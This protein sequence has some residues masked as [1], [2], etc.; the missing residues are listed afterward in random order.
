MKNELTSGF[1]NPPRIGIPG[2]MKLLVMVLFCLTLI[3]CGSEKDYHVAV[4]YYNGDKDTL[5]VHG[6]STGTIRLY[7]SG[8]LY[9]E[10]PDFGTPQ[11]IVCCNVRKFYNLTK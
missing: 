1:K 10:S 6:S 11:E 7:K 2:V 4:V 3:S 5:L 8:C 9:H